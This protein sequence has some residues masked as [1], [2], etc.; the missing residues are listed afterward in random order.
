MKYPIRNL[1]LFT[2]HFPVTAIVSIL[3]RLSGVVLFLL[4]P[5]LLW[6]LQE[7]LHSEAGFLQLKHNFHSPVAQI[8]IWLF[9]GALSY[10]MFAGMRHLLMDIH[11][12]ESKKA[13][14]FSAWIVLGL[15]LFTMGVGGYWIWWG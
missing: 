8:T 13:G 15:T 6:G 2:I 3:H 1:N 12:G 11:I 14:R 9:L 7:S 5:L 4:I 10:H